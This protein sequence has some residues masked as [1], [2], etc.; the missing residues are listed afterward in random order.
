MLRDDGAVGARDLRTPK[1][2]SEVLRVHDRIEGDQEVG[3]C[4][5]ELLQAPLPAWLELRRHALV[6][7][8]REDV[9]ARRLDDLDSREL[10]ELLESRIVTETGCLEDL[11]HPAGAPPRARRCGRRSAGLWTPRAR[12]TRL[13]ETGL[14]GDASS[15]SPV[16]DRELLPAPR[17]AAGGPVSH[18]A[19]LFGLDAHV[20]PTHSL[21]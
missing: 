17:G 12:A 19:S 9:E 3:A 18:Q 7:S 15:P 6:H 8:W 2:G 13:A 11:Q 16:R 4:R 20:L 14:I 21:L 1:D 5:Q 10:A